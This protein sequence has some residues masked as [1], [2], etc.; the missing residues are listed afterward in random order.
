MLFGRPSELTHTPMGSKWRGWMEPESGQ[1]A[2]TGSL[3]GGQLW[4]ATKVAKIAQPVSRGDSHS[5]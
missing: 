2:F 4:P 3:R 1:A 5:Y